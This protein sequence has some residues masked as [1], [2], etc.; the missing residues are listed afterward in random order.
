MPW[1]KALCPSPQFQPYWEQLCLGQELTWAPPP[2]FWDPL[3]LARMAGGFC[4]KHLEDC[5]CP[6]FGI[7]FQ[8]RISPSLN[9]WHLFR[10]ASD[11]TWIFWTL[12][13]GYGS[14]P[15]GN[16]S[17]ALLVVVNYRGRKF[18]EVETLLCVG[19]FSAFLSIRSFKEGAHNN[20]LFMV[21][22]GNVLYFFLLRPPFLPSHWH[23]SVL[24]LVYFFCSIKCFCSL[25]LPRDRS[26][27]KGYALVFQVGCKRAGFLHSVSMLK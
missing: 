24:K 10:E 13:V 9:S 18:R 26:K 11:W 12:A 23:I 14:S 4:P 3:L 8:P 16:M 2:C 1:G 25:R 21:H 27:W 20:V 19:F 6:F 5:C 22:R 7:M 17:H 15:L